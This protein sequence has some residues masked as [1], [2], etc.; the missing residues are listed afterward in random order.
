M[1]FISKLLQIMRS[2][3]LETINDCAETISL[4][5]YQGPWTAVQAAHLLRRATF[6]VD[7]VKLQTAID[8]GLEGAV[9]KLL[10]DLSFPELPLNYDYALDPNVPVG[11]TWVNA[12]FYGANGYMSRSF[13]AWIVGR[14]LSNE[15]NLREKMVLFWHNHFVVES[16]DVND[17]RYLFRYIKIFIENPFGSFRDLVEKVTLDPAMLR[18]LN[19]NQNRRQS[20]N[21]NFARELFELFTLGKGELA[22]PGDYTTFTEDDVRAAARVLTGWQDVGYRNSQT[23]NISVNY[24]NNRHDT[25][26]KQFS[27]RFGNAIINNEGNQEYKRLIDLIF[28][29]SETAEFICRKLYRW[30]VYYKIDET[31]E[32]EIIQELA[33]DLRAADYSIKPVLKKLLSSQHFYDAQ[34]RGCMAKSPVEFISHMVSLIK[35]RPNNTTLLQ[36][37]RFWLSIAQLQRSMQMEYFNAPDVAGWKAYYQEPTFNQLWINPVSIQNRAEVVTRI[38]LDEKNGINFNGTYDVIP[39]IDSFSNPFDINEILDELNRLILPYPFT[40]SQKKAIKEVVLPGLP[41][42]EWTLEYE[43]YKNNPDNVQVKRSLEQKFRMMLWYIMQ[44]PEYQLI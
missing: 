15:F 35:L 29:K 39:L 27:H 26:S 2:E 36:Q 30:F 7:K 34:L 20:P 28:R 21:E 31:I 13:R 6:G 3:E 8:L 5:P 25:G 44:M 38:V 14:Q 32:S 17:P 41:D 43:L 33:A 24:V 19:G 37:Y 18:Y 42:Y 40:E 4:R 1:N 16:R 10:E 12:P 11:D 22:G 9:D 23:F